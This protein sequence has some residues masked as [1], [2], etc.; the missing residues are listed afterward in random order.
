[1]VDL[2]TLTG[3]MTTALGRR[4]AGLFSSDDRLARALLAAAEAAGE[5]LW[6][7]PLVDDYREQ[8]DSD[9][10]DLANISATGTKNG[11][12]AIIA[13]LFLREFAGDRRWAHLDIAG[14]ARADADE[15]EVVKGPTGYG[16][17][18][19]LH[20]LASS[21]PLRGLR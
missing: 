7:M 12:G 3:A 11:G 9:V 4:H 15:H 18:L 10:A 1:V 14:P 13:A 19:L 17:R 5:G 8:L 20:W 21:D 6:R 16:V 2:A